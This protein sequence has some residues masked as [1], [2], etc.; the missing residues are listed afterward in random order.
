LT[1]PSRA[2]FVSCAWQDA[3]A[4]QHICEALRAAGIEV[5]FD[6]SELRGG[7]AWDRTIRQQIRDCALFIPVISVNSQARAE[8]YFRLEWRLAAERTRLG[9]EGAPFVVPVAIDGVK[10]GDAAVPEA[11]RDMQWTR[12]PAQ[13]SAQDFARRVRRLLNTEREVES[14]RPPRAPIVPPALQ[15]RGSREPRGLAIRWLALALLA[16]IVAVGAYLAITR[17]RSSTPP[18]AGAGAALPQS[19]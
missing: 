6:Q 1:E 8:G 3:A 2:I 7:N 14:G 11:F 18:S 15:H 19:R 5:W 4:A 16:I 10:E 13:A 17:H 12:V 9:A